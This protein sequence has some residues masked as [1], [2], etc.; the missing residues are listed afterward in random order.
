MTLTIGSKAQKAKY[1]F[2]GAL[3]H[4]V[5]YTVTDSTYAA[6]IAALHQPEGSDY[7]SSN[8]APGAS[9]GSFGALEVVATW[10]V[11]VDPF[12][13]ATGTMGLTLS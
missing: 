12:F 6:C 10:T 8:L 1:T 7:G 13:D 3:H 4:V 11:E 2:A 9:S 5:T